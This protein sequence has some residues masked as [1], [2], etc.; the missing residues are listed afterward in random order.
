MVYKSQSRDVHEDSYLG[1]GSRNRARLR[2]IK[3]L[4]V[5]AIRAYSIVGRAGN[6]ASCCAG[7]DA[8]QDKV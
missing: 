8:S 5:Q 2:K 7:H 1:S 3:I 6:N 4:E